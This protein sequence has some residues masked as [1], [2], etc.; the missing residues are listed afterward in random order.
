[1]RKSSTAYQP[2][3]GHVVKLR[4]AAGTVHKF[5]VPV[6]VASQSAQAVRLAWA[7]AGA[8]LPAWSV[9]ATDRTTVAAPRGATRVA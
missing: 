5:F 6:A 2:T 3:T 9:S 1:M 8:E 7:A 4:D